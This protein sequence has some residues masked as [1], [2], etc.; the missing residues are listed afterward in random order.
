MGDMIYQNY[1]LSKM[2]IPDDD[3]LKSYEEE[4]FI[5]ILEGRKKGFRP[6]IDK[7]FLL[8]SMEFIS[9]INYKEYVWTSNVR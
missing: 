4:E 8:N 2:E 1:K 9:Q 6:N 5:Y 7:L 3:K